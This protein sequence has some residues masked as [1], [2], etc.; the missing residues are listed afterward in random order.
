MLIFTM[1]GKMKERT[2]FLQPSGGQEA[3]RYR[4]L[5]ARR[6][7]W[8]GDMK[9]GLITEWILLKAVGLGELS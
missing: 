9:V 5:W 6:G 2:G 1:L 4:T 3:S 7:V 8:A